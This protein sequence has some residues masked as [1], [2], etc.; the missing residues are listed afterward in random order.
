MYYI[1]HENG[2]DVAANPPD[3]ELVSPRHTTNDLMNAAAFETFD[4]A[5]D[6]SQNFGPDWHVVGY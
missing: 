5:A 2:N 1:E 3:G 4:E 6:A